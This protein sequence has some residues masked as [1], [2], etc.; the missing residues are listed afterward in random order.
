MNGPYSYFSFWLI[1]PHY[2]QYQLLSKF[3][4]SITK[5]KTVFNPLNQQVT[6][7]L[8]LLITST[9]IKI[10]GHENRPHDQ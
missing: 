6:S 7:N 2:Q 8:F 1:K 5:F 10:Y 9:L 3:L 4:N